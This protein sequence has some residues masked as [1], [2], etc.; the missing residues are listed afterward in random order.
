M[1]DKA[2]YISYVIT[3]LFCVFFSIGIVFKANKNVGTDLQMHY[4]RGMNLFFIMYLLS[5]SFWALG[6]GGIIP[7]SR[8]LNKAA[9][10]L[11]LIAIDMLALLWCVF[12]I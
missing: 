3:E 9:N 4:F 12:V 6:Q 1:D 2:L 8:M 7:F 5:D 11:G 10:A